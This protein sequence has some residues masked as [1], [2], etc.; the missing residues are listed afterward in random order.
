ISTVASRF[1][2]ELGYEKTL[3]SFE[4]VR[5]TNLSD[6]IRLFGL[7]GAAPG[8]D[9]AYNQA[10]G[11]WINY[12]EAE[13]KDRF[14][15]ATL[16]DDRTVRRI[17]EARGKPAFEE[18]ETYERKNAMEGAPVFTKPVSINF[19]SGSS[20]LSAEAIAVINQQILPQMLIARGMSV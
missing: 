5:W 8:F 18:Q 15:P 19:P 11:I 3:K 13:I 9:R 20:D 7:D 10:D 16:R 12:P 17:W 6:N 14:A 4:W 1:R 2:E